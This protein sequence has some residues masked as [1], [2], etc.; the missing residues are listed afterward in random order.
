MNF[1]VIKSSGKQYKVTPGLIFEVD[2]IEGQ[3]GDNVNFSEV[4]L[5]GQDGS[6]LIGT[7]FIKDALVTAK[8]LEQGKGEKVIVSKFKAKSR[9]RRTNG[10][11]AH[12]TKL[13]ITGI[14]GGK[15]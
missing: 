5:L 10:F 7:P 8:I 1:A 13:Q 6:Q 4:L 9:Y 11:R 15:A 3:S 12:L 2:K 14:K